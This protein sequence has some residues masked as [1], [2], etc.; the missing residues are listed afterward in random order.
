VKTWERFSITAMLCLTILAAV[1][2]H[3]VLNRYE[4]IWNDTGMMSPATR[5]DRISGRAW[6][7]NLGDAI[8]EL[9]TETQK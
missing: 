8:E 6:R 7:I 2:L 5:Y 9:G 1:W 3:G 4:V